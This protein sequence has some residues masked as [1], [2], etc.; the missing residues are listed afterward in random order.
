[1]PPDIVIVTGTRPNLVKVAPLVS[2][3]NA[4]GVSPGII[5]T[6]QHY[7]PSMND[8]LIRQLGM[9]RPDWS[10]SVGSA[11]H[12]RQT[13]A[14]MI[15]VEE[16]LMEVRPSWIVTV[17][18]VNSTMAATLAAAK[19]KPRF[20]I[21]LAHVEAGL[22]SGDVRMPEE[23]NRIVT[24]RLSDLLFTHSREAGANL[25]DEGVLPERI[26]FVGNIMIDSLRTH[27]PAARKLKTAK[28][29]GLIT[30]EFGVLTLHRPS[31]VDDPELLASRLTEIQE[32]TPG[33]P[34][35]WPVHPRASESL[36]RS[37][38][39]WNQY[40][41]LLIDAVGYE[42]MLSLLS[43]AAFVLTDSG[44]LQEEATAMGIPCVTL[45]ATTE[46][47]VTVTQGTNTLPAWPPTADGI[48]KA[49]SQSQA[50]TRESCQ[51]ELWDG[52]TAARIVRAIH[53]FGSTR[54]D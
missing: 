49:L 32:G 7:D 23:I 22:R 26:A 38:V 51:P 39:D 35:V 6:G 31:N 48:R 45:R 37:P 12:A 2:A 43:D 19:L 44:G 27:L 17:G 46:R 15:G 29:L 30:G 3:W 52:N 34:L 42:E 5:H 41:L 20:P 16:I 28:S 13:A 36:R 9:P 24:D 40:G 14:V 11:S 1:M 33:V 21:R 25:V 18:D 4:A 50:K 10:L 47:P 54:T 53:T 8:L